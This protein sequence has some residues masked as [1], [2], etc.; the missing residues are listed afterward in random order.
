LEIKVG[1]FDKTRG[2]SVP[3]GR[4]LLGNLSA[5]HEVIGGTRNFISDFHDVI[6]DTRQFISDI[7]E[8]ISDPGNLSAI[9]M[10]LSAIPAI[11]Q[12]FS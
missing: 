10:K 9:F 1:L 3:S 11:Y 6:S 5:I 2:F 8:V 12:R 7:H 4:E